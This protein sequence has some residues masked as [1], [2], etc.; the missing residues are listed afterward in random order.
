ML[1]MLFATILVLFSSC[2]QEHCE[3]M[4][5]QFTKN[6]YLIAVDDTGGEIAIIVRYNGIEE[7]SSVY[8][9]NRAGNKADVFTGKLMKNGNKI[10]A[11][12]F[13]I[14]ETDGVYVCITDLVYIGRATSEYPSPLNVFE[15]IQ[16]QYGFINLNGS[17]QDDPH[18]VWISNGTL[19]MQTQLGALLGLQNVEALTTIG[20]MNLQVNI[21][22]EVGSVNNAFRGPKN[23]FYKLNWDISHQ[24]WKLKF[25]YFA[26]NNRIEY[27]NVFI[28]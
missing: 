4:A 7:T 9:E 2:K 3:P 27:E 13:V 11:G 22:S 16:N 5:E 10:F 28:E 25:V 19:I 6:L 24:K 1:V 8:L 20:E 23:V 12:E 14:E 18:A 21:T 15:R 26:G 17:T